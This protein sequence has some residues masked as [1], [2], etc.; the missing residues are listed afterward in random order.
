MPV[1][2]ATL[3]NPRITPYDLALLQP[4]T[5]KLLKFRPKQVYDQLMKIEVP[6]ISGSNATVKITPYRMATNT[7]K[8]LTSG[9]DPDYAGLQDFIR[10]S[11]RIR[12]RTPYWVLKVDVE[13]ARDAYGRCF[14]RGSDPGVGF[15]FSTLHVPGAGF[16]QSSQYFPGHDDFP[17]FVKTETLEIHNHEMM[18][19]FTGK[20]RPCEVARA[21]FL[22]QVA[23][24]VAPD[25]KSLQAYC[26]EHSG[27]DCSGVAALIYGYV[28]QDHGAKWYEK[29]GTTRTRIED[30]QARDAIVWLGKSNHIAVIDSVSPGDDSTKVNCM[31]VESTGSGLVRSTPGVQYSKYVFECDDKHPTVK[32][33]CW[34]PSVG[35]QPTELSANQVTVQGNVG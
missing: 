8:N 10:R 33:K 20:A 34:R 12:W 27:M 31:V 22:A 5:N 17:A 29:R 13:S 26:D 15:G 25:E 28:G 1:A 3:P 19:F 2:S 30:I 7:P 4:E 32:F 23:G 6:T 14:L 9:G 11:R 21:L 16:G 24:A 35:G 18:R